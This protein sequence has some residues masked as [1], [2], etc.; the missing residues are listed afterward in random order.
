MP[1]CGSVRHMVPRPACRRRA[2]A[3]RAPSAPRSACSVERVVGAVAE[4][5]IH[6]EGE[7]GASRTSPRPARL[8]GFGRPWP[9]YSGSAASAGPA[10]RAEG[11]V[12]LL[13]AR[14]RAHHAVLVAAALLVAGAVERCSTFSASLAASSS[15]LSISVGRRLLV[16]GQGGEP[17]RRRAARAG[18][19]ACRAAG[20]GS[21]HVTSVPQRLAGLEHV[22]DPGER[23]RVAGSGA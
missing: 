4:A 20:R 2:S 5:G 14:G 16:A 15:T 3:G 22:L 21:R 7:V 8:T 17:A 6:A 1:Q 11:R 18:R 23:R 12:G 9:P 13:E 10:A 19:S